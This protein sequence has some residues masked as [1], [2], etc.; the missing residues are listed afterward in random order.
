MDI[1]WNPDET[2]QK[3]F[4]ASVVEKYFPDAAISWQ[5]RNHNENHRMQIHR[6]GKRL[7]RLIFGQNEIEA[8]EDRNNFP[9]L[10]DIVQRELRRLE[11]A[12]TGYVE[13]DG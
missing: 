4:F 5:P 2:R 8:A 13:W 6:A 7:K 9:R 12:D 10:R 1:E 11:R 3:R